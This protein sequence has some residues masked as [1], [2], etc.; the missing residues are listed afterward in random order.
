MT[1]RL[2]QQ[3]DPCGLE[4]TIRFSMGRARRSVTSRRVLAASA[5]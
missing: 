4:G 2:I 3:R 1:V 5:T